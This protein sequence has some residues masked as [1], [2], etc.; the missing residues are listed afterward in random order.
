MTEIQKT[1]NYAPGG[2]KD[3]ELKKMPIGATWVENLIGHG[4]GAIRFRRNSK[5]TA[6]TAGYR[7]SHQGKSFFIQIGQYRI[8]E[9]TAGLPLQDIRNKAQEFATLKRQYP[10]LRAHLEYLEVQ[11]QRQQRTE[12]ET[13]R[14]RT[15]K[16]TFRQLLDGYIADRDKAGINTKEIRR[17]FTK[18]VIEPFSLLLDI[19]ACEIAHNDILTILEPIH[20]RGSLN[21]TDKVR[22][23]LMAAFQYG[24]KQERQIGTAKAGAV[25]DIAT[26]PVDGIGFDSA[27]KDIVN[28]VGKRALSE[29]ELKLFYSSAG[30]DGSRIGF[31]LAQLFRMV[32][33]TGGQRIDQLCR[34]PWDSFQGDYIRIIDAKGKGSVKRVH[35]VP[36]TER[37]R[38]ILAELEPFTGQHSHP[39]SSRPDKP[40]DK[41]SFSESVRRW[42]QTDFAVIDEQRMEHFTPRDLRRTMTQLMQ[43]AGISDSDSDRLQSHGVAGIVDAN[44]RNDPKGSLPSKQRTLDAVERILQ[45]VIDGQTDNIIPL[46]KGESA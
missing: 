31:P 13:E 10:D 20:A 11:R 6:P 33:A 19:P 23:Y 39:F 2:I 22:S 28:K 41:A 16:G 3:N 42:L 35:L 38:Q 8:T 34:E 4:S 9:S 37:T 24:M 21:Q 40:Y 5:N 15:A 26:N 14:Q 45:R 27:D 17:S 29:L 7:Y 18:D 46:R 43:R 44:Y 32:I 30:L 25:Y 36:H 12:I 1:K